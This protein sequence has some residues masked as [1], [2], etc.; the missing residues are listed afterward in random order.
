METVPTVLRVPVPCVT[1][2]GVSVAFKSVQY[3]SVPRTYGLHPASI[4]PGRSSGSEEWRQLRDVVGG[5]LDS[6]EVTTDETGTT[7]KHGK[8]A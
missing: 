1:S 5:I 3:L 2:S 7:I 4:E 6:I 8:A